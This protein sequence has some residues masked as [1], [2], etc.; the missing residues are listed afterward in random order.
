MTYED[1]KNFLAEIAKIAPVKV[2]YHRFANDSQMDVKTLQPIGTVLGDG[3]LF[4]MNSVVQKNL[5]TDFFPTHGNNIIDQHASEVVEFDRCE[6]IHRRRS[7][8]ANGR[9]WFSESPLLGNETKSDPFK[10]WANSLLRWVRSH[11]E[12]HPKDG[13]IAP[14]AFALSNAGK[15]Q[16]GP[17]EEPDIPY[18]EQRR[19]LGLPPQ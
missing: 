3:Q 12:K 7:W 15:L 2:L 9:L 18:E 11:Y 5:K 19:I 6:M 1:E 14:E 13:F 4:I 16:L 10:K 8:L 17:S